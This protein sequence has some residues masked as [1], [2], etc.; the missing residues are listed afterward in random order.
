MPHLLRR[1]LLEVEAAVAAQKK[2]LDRFRA[3]VMVVWPFVGIPWCVPACLAIVEE[4]RSPQFEH[5]LA[6]AE[7]SQ[8]PE[9]DFRSNQEAGLQLMERTYKTVNNSEVRDMLRTYWADFSSLT[10]S[11]VFGYSLGETTATGVF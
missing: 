9:L 7:G 1:S 2:V 11:V 3:V 10:W 8:R 5:L 4:L 6:Y